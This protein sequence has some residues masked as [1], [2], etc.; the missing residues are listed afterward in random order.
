MKPAD[1]DNPILAEL[2]RRIDDIDQQLVRLLNERAEIVVDVGNLKRTDN[3]TPIY[4]PDREQIVLQQIRE[5]NKGPLPDSCLEGIWREL[6]SGSFAL[7]RPLRIGF[8]GPLGSF[9]HLAATRQFGSSVDYTAFESI[10]GVFH[11]VETRRIDLGLVPVENTI[12]GAIHDTLDTFLQTSARVCAEIL[13]PI[14]HHVLSKCA[15]DD[16][17]EKIYTRPEVFDQCR[18]WLSDHVRK[19]ERMAAASTARA[20]EVAA[21][22]PGTAAIG[23]SLA[24]SIY[25][26]PILHENIED[27]PN[28]ITRFFVIGHQASRPSGDDK[29][30]ILFTTAHKP[31]ALAEVIDAFRDKGVN[32]THIDK[33][34]SQR[35]NWEYCFFIDCE[36]HSEEEHVA[37]AIESAR[38]HCLQLTI[39]GSFPRAT[40]VLL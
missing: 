31:G 16:E 18:K 24:A 22:D 39:L 19:A 38:N 20:A 8:L 9:S 3:S 13:I 34:P 27:N 37:T 4:A 26:V 40:N 25:N 12:G 14:Q 23:S 2:R 10:P 17:I 36:G 6:M 32:L 35:V 5:Y 30:A 28:N 15:S 11:G 7:E 21:S 33:R 29:T 1:N